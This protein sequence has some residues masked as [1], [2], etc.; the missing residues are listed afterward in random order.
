[1]RAIHLKN[2]LSGES[3]AGHPARGIGQIH[4]DVFIDSIV[5]ILLF[6]VL[7]LFDQ[8]GK[9]RYDNFLFFAFGGIMLLYKN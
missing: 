6:L 3:V 2:L 7:D 4:L 9:W 5:V 8:W 1:M